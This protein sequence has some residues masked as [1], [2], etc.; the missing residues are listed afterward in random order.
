MT[1]LVS[2][3]N[4]NHSKPKENLDGVQLPHSYS[5]CA[6]DTFEINI[7]MNFLAAI[8]SSSNIAVN[9]TYA[10]YSMV[11]RVFG[12]YKSRSKH[13]SIV[14]AELN[15]ELRPARINYFAKITAFIDEV[16]CSHILVCLSWFKHHTLKDACG[17]PVTIWEYNLFD[18]TTFVLA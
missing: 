5:K 16:L 15:N 6:F 12:S 17:K 10:S 9:S 4:Q 3:Q 1:Q 11:S 8:H 2:S 18:S 14:F 7:L 13:S